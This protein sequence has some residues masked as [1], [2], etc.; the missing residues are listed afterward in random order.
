MFPKYYSRNP[1]KRFGQSSLGQ[2]GITYNEFEKSLNLASD[3]LKNYRGKVLKYD[4][5]AIGAIVFGILL[6]IIIGMA[7]SGGT[8]D[9][10]SNWSTML[11]LI[12]LFMFYLYA[13]YKVT[14]HVQCKYLR[15][16]HFMLAV[17]CRVENN[18][19]FLSRGIE[20][21]PGYLARWIEFNVLEQDKG[22]S[23]IETIL[24]RINF[25]NKEAQK[26]IEADHQKHM[27]GVNRDYTQ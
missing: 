10:T 19:Y 27:D 21:R 18:R 22:H 6:I 7:T 12:F 5:A 24:K 1:G 23:P 4:L 17:V 3:M 25:E 26:N 16:A 8:E 13:V 11:I 14:K 15:Q 9:D 2:K 20:L